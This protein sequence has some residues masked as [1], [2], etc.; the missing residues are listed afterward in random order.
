MIVS[1]ML[2]LKISRTKKRLSN[3]TWFLPIIILASMG[4]L[5]TLSFMLRATSLSGMYGLVPT[6]LP[7]VH[8]P[9]TEDGAKRRP[10][11][12]RT[13]DE[14]SAIIVLTKDRFIFGSIDSFTKNLHEV[15]EKFTV[16][17]VKGV[18]HLAQLSI[19]LSK[20]R[21]QNQLANNT[22]AVLI[23]TG[24]IPAP[25]MIQTLAFLNKDQNFSQVVL[26]G[27]IL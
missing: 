9:L 24:H 12:T 7:I 11:T 25:V 4:L 14:K 27:G 5:V 1:T 6:T 2:Q 3:S 13:I 21:E 22:V 17:H 18:P 15:R 19:D 8:V 20:W 16:A 10:E 23:P 26:G